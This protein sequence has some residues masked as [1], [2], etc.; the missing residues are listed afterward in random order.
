MLQVKSFV[1]NE[2]QENTY[3]VWDDSLACAII[4][5]GCSNSEERN[6]LQEFIVKLGLKPSLL[7]NT[8]CHIDHILGNNFVADKYQLPLHLH[9]GELF[10]YKDTDRWAAMFGLPKFTIPE[11]LVFIDAGQTLHFGSSQLEILSTPGHSIAS[12]SFYHANTN[13]LFGGDVIFKNSIGRTDLPGGNFEV[14]AQ[15]I[16]EKIYTLPEETRIYSGHGPSTTVGSE[17]LN[18]PYVKP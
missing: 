12:L 5:P 14:L 8:H 13:I 1:F 7:L 2:F 9:E 4:D 15:S 3:V 18:N 10:T 6:L 16:R 17:K 11:K